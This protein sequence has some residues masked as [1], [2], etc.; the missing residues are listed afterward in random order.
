MTSQPPLLDR[1]GENLPGPQFTP[2]PGWGGQLREW[3]T[4]NAYIVV[5]RLVIFAALVLVAHS[6]WVHLPAR[7]ADIRASATPTPQELKGLTVKAN[8]GDG[9]TNLAARA[10]DLYVALQTSQLRLSAAQHLAAVD[11]LSRSVCWCPVARDQIVTFAT[12]DIVHAIDSALRLS[13]AAL[14]AWSAYLR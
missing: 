6:L 11:T 7:T 4:R 9:M 5:F 1:T 12:A 2:R 14:R 13:P 3:F 8:P 10:L